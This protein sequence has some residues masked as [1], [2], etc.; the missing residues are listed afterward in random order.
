MYY[1]LNPCNAIPSLFIITIVKI[2]N[3]FY[4]D[5]EK[6]N[7]ITKMVIDNIF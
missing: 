2:L 6:K 4:T 1:K 3:I 7:Y 5:F